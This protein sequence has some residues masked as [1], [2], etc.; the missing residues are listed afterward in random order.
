MQACPLRPLS[1]RRGSRR[2]RAGR[3]NRQTPRSPAADPNRT[4]LTATGAMRTTLRRDTAYSHTRWSRWR[5][6]PAPGRP[7]NEE[8]DEGEQLPFRLAELVDAG[9]SDGDVF[10]NRPTSRWSSRAP[11]VTAT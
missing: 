11:S 9:G 1:A 7:D 8:E 4:R 6:P 10:I 2:R 3:T 5:V